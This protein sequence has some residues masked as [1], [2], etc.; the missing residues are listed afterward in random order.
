MWLGDTPNSNHSSVKKERKDLNDLFNPPSSTTVSAPSTPPSL[1]SLSSFCNNIYNYNQTT[2]PT[3]T[4]TT[5]T[6]IATT[7]TTNSFGSSGSLHTATRTVNNP[8]S[9][10]YFPDTS[11]AFPSS[12][13]FGNNSHQS[14]AL[15]NSQQLQSQHASSLHQ[16][17][18]YGGQ[19]RCTTSNSLSKV[20]QSSTDK[21]RLPVMFAFEINLRLDI[22]S[23]L[24]FLFRRSMTRLMRPVYAAGSAGPVVKK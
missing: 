15:S 8:S 1:I 22:R 10:F 13:N 23:I 18:S 12:S 3:T 16:Q 7:S 20:A 5:S 19:Y 14:Q 9:S 4:A 2:A 11:A 6:V 21:V 17:Q 24:L